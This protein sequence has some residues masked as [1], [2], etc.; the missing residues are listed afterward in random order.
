MRSRYR[1]RRIQDSLHARRRSRAR[2]SGDNHLINGRLVPSRRDRESKCYLNLT[3]RF[4]PS[5]KAAGQGNDWRATR[6]CPV[7]P[8]GGVEHGRREDP[9]RIPHRTLPPQA[10]RARHAT[11]GS[12]RFVRF[13]YKNARPFPAA[14]TALRPRPWRAISSSVPSS[15]IRQS[16]GRGTPPAF[17]GAC[18]SSTRST[19]IV[20]VPS[21][22][23]VAVRPG[24]S[25]REGTSTHASSKV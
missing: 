23:Q 20:T 9:G 25:N 13:V 19:R 18:Y 2:V 22:P 11:A 6:L 1:S 5:D 8:L 7:P 3:A 4:E 10:C 14:E 15:G 16:S 17:R 24:R 12:L 21:R